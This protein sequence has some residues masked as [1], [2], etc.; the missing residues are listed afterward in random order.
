LIEKNLI[1]DSVTVQVLTQARELIDRT[2]EALRGVKR[3]VVHVT[4]RRR[5][6]SASR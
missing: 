6:Y 4:T 1:P 3:A 2:F 5:R